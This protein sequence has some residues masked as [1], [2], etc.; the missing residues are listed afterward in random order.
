MKKYI[1][2]YFR[3]P[4]DSELDLQEL[5]IDF[6]ECDT[7]EDAHGVRG[8]VREGTIHEDGDELYS[9]QELTRKVREYARVE[10]IV[11]IK[12]EDYRR[13]L[14]ISDESLSKQ[15]KVKKMTDLFFQLCRKE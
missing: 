14:A 3:F 13:A 12:E 8:A 4:E 10:K 5:E 15:E 7:D 2:T 6:L 1:A 9:I 11:Q